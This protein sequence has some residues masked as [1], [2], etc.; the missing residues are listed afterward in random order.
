M[1]IDLIDVLHDM[2]PLFYVACMFLEKKRLYMLYR[3]R[4]WITVSRTNDTWWPIFFCTVSI[5]V[6]RVFHRQDRCN[7]AKIESPFPMAAV[8]VIPGKKMLLRV[9]RN[10]SRPVAR[11]ATLHRSQIEKTRNLL[12]DYR[13]SI[14]SCRRFIC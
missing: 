3:G 1:L 5:S 14:C 10:D 8:T 13:Y 9:A 11:A 2:K 7:H 4:A 12:R 6:K